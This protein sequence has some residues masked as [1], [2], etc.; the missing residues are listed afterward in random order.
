MCLLS[1]PVTIH[2]LHMSDA[3]V[4]ITHQVEKQGFGGLA[5]VMSVFWFWYCWGPSGIINESIPIGI[6][7]LVSGFGKCLQLHKTVIMHLLYKKEVAGGSMM[8]CYMQIKQWVVEVKWM[9]LHCRH[10]DRA[11]YSCPSCLFHVYCIHTLSLNAW[12]A[13]KYET[14]NKHT[15][16][17][18]WLPSQ[19]TSSSS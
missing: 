12:N 2:C 8:Y 3:L 16:L 18:F 1:E 15:S 5:V 11:R 14:Q 10:W 4:L 7:C 17:S 9:H 6:V 13:D 19:T